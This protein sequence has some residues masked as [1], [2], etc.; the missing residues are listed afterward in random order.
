MT[1]NGSSTTEQTINNLAV[2][3][4]W[5][6][7]YRGFG[8]ST[9]PSGE[10]W[11]QAYNGTDRLYLDPVPSD[12]IDDLLEIKRTAGAIRV[13]EA[14]R[15]I[16]QVD[17]TPNQSQSTYETQYVG[18]VDLDGKLVP[19]NKPGRAV[20]V[21]PNGV[22]PGDLWPGVYDGAKYSFSGERF[23]WE[24]SDTKLRHSFAD[25]LPQPIVDE[26]NRLRRQG[27][28]FQIT[29]AGDVLTQIPTAKSPPDVRSQFRDLPREVKRILQ[30]RRDRG[31]VDM[32]P[33]YV[34]HLEPSER[35]ILVNEPTRL[36]DP[37]TEQEEAGLEAWAAAMGSYDESE[38]DEDDHRAGGS[39]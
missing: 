18:S 38:L 14:G 30:L 15:V 21:S 9:N 22:S 3:D 28:S 1:S 11:W 36:T 27:G 16:T 24:N 32:L 25:S 5:P 29:P 34:G 2:G 17:T 4:I 8:L 31:K 19:E 7:H 23:W 37:L 20:E 33:V 10:I 13:T 39:R 12:L 26:L 35:P 6:F